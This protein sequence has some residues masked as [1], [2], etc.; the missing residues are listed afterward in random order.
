MKLRSLSVLGTL[1][2]AS[3][4]LGACSTDTTSYYFDGYV[5]DG[6]SGVVLTAYKIELQYLDRT[7]HGDVDKVGRYFMGPLTPF[8]DYVVTITADGYRPFQSANSM[9]LDDE[10]TMNDNSHDDNTHPDRSQDY[11]AYLFT[12]TAQAAASTLTVSLADDIN[13]PSGVITLMPAAT[14]SPNASSDVASQVWTN[15]ADLH[16]PTITKS[17]SGGTVGLTAGELVYGVT[18]TVTIDVAG[19][20]PL[21]TTYTAGVQGD[22]QY[23]VAAAK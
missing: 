9:K 15:D 11:D 21:V 22:A 17:F 23:I 1:L 8:N 7:E 19:H 2:G 10:Q 5:Y 3:L 14:K 4:S 12:T 6:Q 16:G 20:P 18:Y 13:A